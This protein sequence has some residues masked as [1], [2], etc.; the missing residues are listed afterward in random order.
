MIFVVTILA[1][2]LS[3]LTGDGGKALFDCQGLRRVCSRDNGAGNGDRSAGNNCLFLFLVLSPS[4]QNAPTSKAIFVV[5]FSKTATLPQRFVKQLAISRVSA[6][7]YRRRVT[8]EINS[9][10]DTFSIYSRLLKLLTSKLNKF[11]SYL[12]QDINRLAQ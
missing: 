7:P 8:F 11:N 5:Q 6:V 9:K 12:Q 4:K 3:T 2:L 1:F 10:K